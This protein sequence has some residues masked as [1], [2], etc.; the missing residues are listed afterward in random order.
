MKTAID[1]TC[2]EDFEK[3]IHTLQKLSFPFALE[4]S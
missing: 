2:K 1:I 3:M 4:V